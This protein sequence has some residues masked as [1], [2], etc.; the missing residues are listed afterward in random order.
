MLT[1]EFGSAA[2]DQKVLVGPVRVVPKEEGALGSLPDL[3]KPRIREVEHPRLRPSELELMPD[4]EMDRHL[5]IGVERVSGRQRHQGVLFF[6]DAAFVAI[7]VRGAQGAMG[8]LVC[9]MEEGR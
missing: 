8:E 6:I 2:L 7:H 5:V 3:L 1:R 9:Q 4:V